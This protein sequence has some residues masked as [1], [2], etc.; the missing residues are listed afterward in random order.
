MSPP[1]DGPAAAG[2]AP[3]PTRVPLRA[4]FD[5]LRRERWFL[6]A[7]AIGFFLAGVSS[8]Y[9][10]VAMWVGFA[11]AAYSAVANDSIQTIGTFISSNRHR[12]WWALWLFMGGIFLATSAWSFVFY[13]GDVSFGRLGA[14]GFETA[15]TSFSFLQVAAPLVLM[16]L[17]RMRMPVS[18][19]LLLLSGFTTKAEGITDVITKSLSGYV[20]ALAAAMA[21]WLALGPW[22]RRRFVGEAHVAWTVGQWITSGL[23]WSVWLQQD[24]ANV[25]VYLPR[26]LGPV[27]FAAFCV[28]I[29]GGLGLL[30]WQG[31][32]RIQEVVDEKSDV[33]DVRSATVI[34]LVYTVILYVFKEHSNVPMSTTWVFIGLLGGRELAMSLRG[35]AEGDRTVKHALKLMGR[36]LLYATIG[37][38]VALLLAAAVNPVAREGL[39]SR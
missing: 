8:P 14:K 7:L 30:F 15:P 6:M 39:F 34:D 1:T 3:P 13:G 10:P 27:E 16:V 23:L 11:F 29:F 28:T 20:V 31:G 18:T 24:A 32:E 5:L 9:A 4:F 36:D 17:T 35:A 22:M 26:S 12:P 37:F 21:V 33:V 25:A 38:I 2:T 19:T